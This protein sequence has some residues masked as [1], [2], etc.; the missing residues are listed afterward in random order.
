MTVSLRMSA[1]ALV[2]AAPVALAPTLAHAAPATAT[3]ITAPA[4]R[5]LSPKSMNI[6]FADYPKATF[7][8]RDT[9]WTGFKLRHPDGGRF[10][11]QVTRWANLV[12]AVMGE[13]RIAAKYLPGIL[14]QIQQESSG[15][16]YA[17]NRWDSNAAAGMP[18]KG[19]LQIIAPTYR[20][21]AK[22]GWR[23]TRYQMT[24]YL[25]IWASLNYVIDRY[26]KRKFKLWNKG[27]NQGY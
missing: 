7:R 18:S 8:T 17:V 13:H 23:S 12:L 19:L 22:P 9:P 27:Q 4:E 1:A 2:L 11:T 25:N 21:Y 3:A 20:A 5:Q 10:P 15:D 16:P 26:G 24:P 14:A 6:P